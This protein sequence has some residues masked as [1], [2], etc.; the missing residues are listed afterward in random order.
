MKISDDSKCWLEFRSTETLFP[1]WWE[2][3]SALPLW[4][5]IWHYL[6][7]LNLYLLYDSAVPLL[8]IYPIDTLV[9]VDQKTYTR[10]FIAAWLMSPKLENS[11]VSLSRMNKR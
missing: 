3:K 5:I 4:K 10:M 8:G 1:S 2:Y 7:N 6:V 11:L 9:H